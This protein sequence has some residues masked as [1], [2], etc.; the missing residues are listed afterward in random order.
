[1]DVAFSNG[2]KRQYERL[3]PDGDGAVLVVPMLSLCLTTSNGS[4]SSPCALS[5]YKSCAKTIQYERLKPDGDGA[6][7]VVP[8][9]ARTRFKEITHWA[10]I[11][12]C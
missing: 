5:S 3:K 2:E 10:K 6:V 9:L 4:G 1:M 12:F 8:M 11:G 7:L